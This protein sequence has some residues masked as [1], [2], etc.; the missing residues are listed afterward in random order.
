MEKE[1]F[2][3]ILPERTFII[4]NLEEARE[5]IERYN[6]YGITIRRIKLENEK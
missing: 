1:K 6:L 5:I 4:N 3:L 2:E